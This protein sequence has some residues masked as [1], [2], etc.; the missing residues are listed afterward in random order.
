MNPDDIRVGCVVQSRAGRDKGKYFMVY[1]IVDT[2]F[3]LVL[4]GKTRKQLAP[5]RKRRKHV[6]ATGTD[7]AV[8]AQ[9]LNLGV[10]VFDAEIR[11]AL[12]DAGYKNAAG[13]S[14]KEG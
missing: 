13:A 3:I 10:H 7:L 6:K 14:K 5:K 2:E 4:D 1:S 8:I 12:E 11:K 9:K